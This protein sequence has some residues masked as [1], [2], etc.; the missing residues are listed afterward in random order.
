MSLKMTNKI[1]DE[2]KKINNNINYIKGTCYATD[3]RQD[4]IKN[5][6]DADILYIIGDKTSN[7]TNKL[8]EIA[9]ENNIKKV[10]LIDNK[11]EININDLKDEYNVYV[12]AGASTPPYLID[13]TIEY[14]N[15]IF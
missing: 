1:A 7:N 11:N 15:S 6:K 8:K 10:Y 3:A 4:A 13:E 14:L 5:I 2:L 12:S 9:I